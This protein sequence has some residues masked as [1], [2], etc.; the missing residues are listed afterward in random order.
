MTDSDKDQ[1]YQAR[2][3]RK[4]QLIDDKVKQADQ[5]RGVVILLK[6]NGKGKSSSAFGMV[7]RALGHGLK[8]GV[9]QFIKGKW[10]SGEQ[11]LLADHPQVDWVTM[12]TGFTW[13][14]QNL[15][16]DI[17]AAERTWQ[18]ALKML[19]DPS[20]NLVVLDEITYMYQYDYLPQQEL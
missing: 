2:M 17:D 18:P 3:Q 11:L 10:Q 1:R 15:Q 13:D 9:V 7:A 6:G 19:A 12:G 5:E 16:A 20:I 8:V 4:K 14:T